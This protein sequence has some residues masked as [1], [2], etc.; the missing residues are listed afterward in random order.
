MVP[1]LLHRFF[2]DE[3]Y[4]AAPS[5]IPALRALRDQQ[6]QRRFDQIIIGVITNS[7]DRVPSVL[8]SL[9]VAVSPL[10]Y[11]TNLDPG[12]AA[13]QDHDIDFHCISYDVGVEKPNKLIFNAA[14]LMLMQIIAMRGG[15]RSTG[16][17]SEAATWQKIYVGDEYV[18]DAVG[19][20]DA[21]WNSVLLEGG[22][23]HS[24]L[25]ALRDSSAQ[26]VHEL[27]KQSNIITVGSIQELTTWLTGGTK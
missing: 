1:K 11:G 7:D 9:G 3:G 6:A 5:L 24:D 25:T 21:G 27:F 8:S 10:R 2:S 19:A 17:Q 15:R 16:A 12:T 14:E 26:S 20:A 22:E 23:D 13:A 4:E 18:K